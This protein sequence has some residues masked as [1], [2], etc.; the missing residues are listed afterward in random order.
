MNWR[1]QV[2]GVH[3]ETDFPNAHLLR[4]IRRTVGWC[5]SIQMPA[6]TAASST[7]GTT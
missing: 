2:D 5:T 7:I 6:A 1:M 3:D 4:A